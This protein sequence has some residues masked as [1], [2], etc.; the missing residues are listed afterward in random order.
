MPKSII[1]SGEEK[2]EK[3]IEALQ[4]ELSLIRAGRANPNILN[5]VMVSYYGISTPLN[6][7]ASISVPEAQLLVIKPY[8]KTSLDDIQKAIQLA[9]LNLVPQNDGTVIRVSFPALT[10]ER[11]KEFVKDAKGVVEKSK[12]SIRNIRRDLIDQLKKL[13]KDS[14]ISEDELRI[15]SDE[16][17]E[18]T[19]KFIDKIDKIGKEKEQNIMEI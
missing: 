8:D 6:Q 17:Q 13:E 10:E 7:I 19:D 5:G 11:R 1:N 18:L 9:D 2:M 4:K 3:A 12:I 14:E 15:R 16:V